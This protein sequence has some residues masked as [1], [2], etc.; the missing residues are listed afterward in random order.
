M[1]KKALILLVIA[2]MAFGI[3]WMSLWQIRDR[4]YCIIHDVFHQNKTIT[5]TSQ[6]D[7][8]L[9]GFEE[10]SIK[11]LPDDFLEKSGMK[12]PKYASMLKNCS[13]YKISPNNIYQ[14]IAGDT[15]IR[16]LV[17]RDSFFRA[18]IMDRS[19]SIYWLIDKRILYRIVELRDA[20]R[21]KGYNEDG[22]TITYGNRSPAL[23]EAIK[24]A[25]KSRHIAGE[26]VDMTIGDI[27]GDGRYSEEDKDIVLDILNTTIIR[28]RGGIGRYPG[29]RTVHMDV[30]GWRARWDSY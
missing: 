24:G 30:R 28:S 13:F 7:S 23:N 5:Q 17:S 26:A 19:Q 25:S 3:G 4:S 6:T 2:I 12:L 15:R 9:S 11:S 20:L 21:E 22:F 10:I 8:I 1:L 14:K 29:T 18:A 16:D 27:N